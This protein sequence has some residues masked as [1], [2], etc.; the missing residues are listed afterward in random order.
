MLQAE[1]EQSEQSLVISRVD[2]VQLAQLT[3]EDKT[4]EIARIEVDGGDC[5]VLLVPMEIETAAF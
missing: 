1:T 4:D 3:V 2:I 5:I